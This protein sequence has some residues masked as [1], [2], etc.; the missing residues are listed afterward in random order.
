MSEE[1]SLNKSTLAFIAIAAGLIGML[2]GYSVTD[3]SAASPAATP[4]QSASTVSTAS[5]GAAGALAYR[6]I[7]DS[8]FTSIKRDEFGRAAPYNIGENIQ[9]SDKAFKEL[10]MEIELPLDA[11]VEYKLLMDQGDAAVYEWSVDDGEVYTDFHAHPPGEGEFFT[12]YSETE[13]D[14]DQGAIVAAY[15]GQHGWFWL[16]ISDKPVTV[17]L[18]VAGF[19]DDLIEIDLEAEGY[20]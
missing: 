3:K 7:A 9:T 19:Y 10:T 12:R 18:K 11:T 17:V 4:T 13:G 15:S 16:N 5:T 8:E 20:E 6:Y 2:L 1:K 14:S